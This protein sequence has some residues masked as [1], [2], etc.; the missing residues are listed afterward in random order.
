MQPFDVTSEKNPSFLAW[1]YY[2]PLADED[3]DKKLPPRLHAHADMDVLTILFQRDGER[4]N[5]EFVN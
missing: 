1:N 5:E 2:P 4:M 3:L